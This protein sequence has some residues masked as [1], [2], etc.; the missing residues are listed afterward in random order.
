MV[1]YMSIQTITQYYRYEKKTITN[2]YNTNNKLDYRYVDAIKRLK[3]FIICIYLSIFSILLSSIFYFINLDVGVYVF[4]L[5]FFYLL[6]LSGISYYISKYLFMRE[7]N[8]K[9]KEKRINWN[10]SIIIILLFSLFYPILIIYLYNLKEYVYISIIL[11]VYFISI[12]TI[13]PIVDI[14]LNNVGKNN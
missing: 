14:I 7:I 11:I 10:T 9:Y 13:K 8:D 12:F 6:L 2:I 4:S 3:F 5:F 1:S